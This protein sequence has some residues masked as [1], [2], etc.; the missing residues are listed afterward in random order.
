MVFHFFARYTPVGKEVQRHRPAGASVAAPFCGLCHDHDAIFRLPG[1]ATA[2][3]CKTVRG[4]GA[5]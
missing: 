5:S 2:D 3:A 1:K 4:T